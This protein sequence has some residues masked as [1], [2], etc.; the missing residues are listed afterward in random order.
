MPTT[1]PRIMVTETDEL[2]AALDSAAVRYPGLSRAQLLTRLALE[3]QRVAQRVQEDRRRRR[4]DVLRE[5]S[6]AL[7]GAYGADYLE[8]LRQEWPA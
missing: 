7:T 3:G 4:L 1:R 6:G 2:A 8:R 5:H